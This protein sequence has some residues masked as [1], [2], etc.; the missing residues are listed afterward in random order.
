[1]DFIIPLLRQNSH[2]HLQD[3]FNACSIAF[4]NNRGGMGNRFSDKALREYTKALNGTNAALRSTD[5]QLSDSTLAAVLLLGL[6]EVSRF[7]VAEY[8]TY[9][10]R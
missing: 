4:L 3:A 5:S 7:C 9:L 8:P 1:M 2:G 6:F 10:S